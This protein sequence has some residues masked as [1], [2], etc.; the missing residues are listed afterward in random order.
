MNE[1][2]WVCG[3]RELVLVC[4]FVWVCV[5]VNIN[6]YDLCMAVRDWERVSVSAWVCVS[7]QADPDKVSFA[8]DGAP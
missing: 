4:T 5:S 7:V 6:V 2:E 8:S 1:S 3:A